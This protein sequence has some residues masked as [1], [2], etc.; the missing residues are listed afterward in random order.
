[1]ALYVLLAASAHRPAAR[2]QEPCVLA[3]GWSAPEANERSG[4]FVAKAHAHRAAPTCPQSR[5]QPI[6]A[7]TGSL[8]TSAK[9]S[10]CLALLGAAAGFTPSPVRTCSPSSHFARFTAARLIPYCVL[11][12]SHTD[13]QKAAKSFLSFLCTFLFFRIS[14]SP[15][16]NLAFPRF[17]FLFPTSLSVSI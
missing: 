17:A 11:T 6:S 4:S 10:C 1:M 13:T 14:P 9:W 3:G 12:Q 7:S 16:R 8:R 5:Q 2:Q 15:K